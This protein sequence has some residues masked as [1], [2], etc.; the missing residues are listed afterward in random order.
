[1]LWHSICD[2][3]PEY[4]PIVRV[5]DIARGKSKRL[6][7][8]RATHNAQ[9]MTERMILA[10]HAPHSMMSVAVPLR[11]REPFTFLRGARLLFC[12]QT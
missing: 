4:N 5:R 12:Y 3:H 9:N 8:T 10:L 6:Q 2:P 1:M 11:R 7:G